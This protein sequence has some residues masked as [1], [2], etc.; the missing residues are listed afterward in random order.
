VPDLQRRGGTDAQAQAGSAQTIKKRMRKTLL[1]LFL[2]LPA[3]GSG[4]PQPSPIAPDSYTGNLLLVG[5]VGG[6]RPVCGTQPVI[7]SRVICTDGSLNT[8]T[9]IC[10]DR[11]YAC[12]DDANTCAANK[13]VLCWLNDK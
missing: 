13:G 3:C 2:L 5:G 10:T 7:P 9:A 1:F 8:P 12:T 4:P 6:N 11:R